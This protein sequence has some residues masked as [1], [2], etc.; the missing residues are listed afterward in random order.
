VESRSEIPEI[1]SEASEGF[2]DLVFAI[3]EKSRSGDG[4]QRLVASGVAKGTP[5]G[6]IAELGPTWKRDTLGATGIVTHQG[7]VTIRSP[8]AQGDSL[9]GAIDRI[10]DAAVGV[11]AM[12]T[13]T[14]FA[15][16]ALEGDPS[17][18][19]AGPVK[20]KLFFESENEDRYAECFLNIDLAKSRVHLNEKDPDYRKALVRALAGG[21]R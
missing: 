18:L 16:I 3:H 7:T 4:T 15:A 5:V 9:V 14:P 6:F 10:Y 8:G 17:A 11:K 2:H 19:E 13:S 12:A 20:L 1:E 21:G